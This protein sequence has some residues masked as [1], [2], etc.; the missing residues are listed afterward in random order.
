VSQEARFVTAEECSG[1]LGHLVRPKHRSALRL[2]EPRRLPRP[3]D[4]RETADL[5]G[6]L[7]SWP[8]EAIAGMLLC[9]L[10]SCEVLALDVAD[11]DVGARWLQV[12][13]KGGKERREPL[14]V[15]VAGLIQA[16]LLAER[17]ETDCSRVFVVA[18]GPPS[19]LA[20]RTQP[21]ATWPLAPVGR[22]RRRLSHY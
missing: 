11:V 14:D 8:D 19:N 18:K 10:R 15:D 5:L 16:Y 21:R 3:L 17:P 2:P 12:S 7:R 13:G 22:C 20:V 9:G 1:L 4:R 6:S